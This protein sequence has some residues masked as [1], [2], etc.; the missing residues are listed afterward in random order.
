MTS[1]WRKPHGPVV[2]SNLLS[3]AKPAADVPGLPE[4]TPFSVIPIGPDSYAAKAAAPRRLDHAF[5]VSARGCP[6][7]AP[8]PPEWKASVSES[9]ERVRWFPKLERIQLTRRHEP[10]P[11]LPE[12]RTA[13]GP[14]EAEIKPF[15][16]KPAVCPPEPASRQSCRLI[17]SQAAITPTLLRLS[18]NPPCLDERQPGE[19]GGVSPAQLKTVM[20]SGV[21]APV[22]IR[23]TIES[24]VPAPAEQKICVTSPHIR[25]RLPVL[26]S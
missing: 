6:P 26:G 14:R 13:A 11:H 25:V 21:P 20:S 5:P 17:S 24:R 19:V 22:G 9:A 4:Q 23:I 1:D 3:P 8:V 16:R 7:A 18:A 15:V 10:V 2:V 12:L